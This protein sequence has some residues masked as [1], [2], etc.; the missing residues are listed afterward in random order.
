MNILPLIKI[1]ATTL[2]TARAETNR[3]AQYRDCTP[4]SLDT[5]RRHQTSSGENSFEPGMPARTSCQPERG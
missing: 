4:T 3:A 5:A 1:A 2:M